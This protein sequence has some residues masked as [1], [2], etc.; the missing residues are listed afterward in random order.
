M[1]PWFHR[2]LHRNIMWA[3]GFRRLRVGAKQI[4]K[5]RLGGCSM[6][7]FYAIFKR[8][9]AERATVSTCRNFRTGCERPRSE[10]AR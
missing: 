2:L 5:K 4:S 3:R 8:S 6:P 7:A 10:V 1:I 9:V